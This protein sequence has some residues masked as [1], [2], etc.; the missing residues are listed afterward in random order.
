MCLPTLR[1][2]R[3]TLSHRQMP[4]MR[5]GDSLGMRLGDLKRESIRTLARRRDRWMALSG[6]VLA[7]AGLVPIGDHDLVKRNRRGF[8]LAGKRAPVCP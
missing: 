4:R 1:R 7:A 5:N 2:E 6:L 3:N 8:R